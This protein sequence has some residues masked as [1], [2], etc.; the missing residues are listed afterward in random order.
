MNN[1]YLD[2]ENFSGG[3]SKEKRTLAN[4]IKAIL[5]DDCHDNMF[6]LLGSYQRTLADNALR[7]QWDEIHKKVHSLFSAGKAV[8]LDGPMIG[9]PVSIRDSDYFRETAKLF[10][11]ERSIAADIEWMATAWNSTFADTGLWMGKAF[12]PVSREV[13]A[14][15]TKDDEV[16]LAAYDPAITRIGRNYFRSPPDPNLLQGLSLPALT[17][18]WNLRKRPTLAAP[19]IFDTKLL[20]ENEKKEKNIPYTLTGGIFLADLGR[21][22]VP[23]MKGKAVYQLNY[24]W[25]RLNP[26]YP[27][28]R[29]V[30]EVVQIADGLYLGQLIYATQNYALHTIDADGAAH[31]LGIDYRP[32]QPKSF[33]DRLAFWRQ[34][35]EVVDYGYQNNGYFLMMDPDYAKQ[36]YADDAFPQL[37]PRAGE[38]GYQELGYDQSG[39]VPAIS[40]EPGAM[41]WV[42]GW[43]QDAKLA[44]KFTSFILEESPNP[45]DNNG[46]EAL[47]QEGESILQMLQRISNEISRQTAK[48]DQLRHFDTLSRL[49][50]CGVAPRV[51]EGVFQRYRDGAHNVLANGQ[52]QRDW[53][54]KPD[55]CT[56]F[57]Y[58]HGATLNLHCGFGENFES[59]AKVGEDNREMFPSILGE[60]LQLLLGTDPNI[61]NSTWQSI[62][63]YIFPWAGKSYEKVSG[64]K[65]SML[66]D[67]STDLTDR[68]PQRVAELKKY[69]ASAPHYLTL[70]KNQENFWGTAGH[71][72]PYL[73]NGSWDNGMSDEQKAFWEKESADHWVFGNN[74]QDARILPSDPLMN[75]IDMNYRVPDPTL[76]A[77]SE[78]GPS[79]FARQGY[80]FLGVSERDSILPMNNTEEKKKQVFQFQYRFP[81]IGGPAPIGYCLDEIVELADGLFLGQLIY[82]T[83]LDKTFHSGVDPSVYKYQLFGYFLLLDDDW[84]SHRK[85]IGLDVWDR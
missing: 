63:K 4:S 24:R 79:P 27:M 13:V 65:L 68:Y 32:H 50:R 28:T 66:L 57:D 78:T 29:L 51:K 81:M 76:Q 26:V 82:S 6:A 37:R 1:K 15:R 61:L 2:S 69:P 48:D 77:L 72:A 60:R 36:V 74:L 40:T 67:E 53:Y 75:I 52:Q 8:P 21:S 17:P 33:L 44:E 54:G 35:E 16:A 43:K 58:Y 42:E 62:G 85:A 84:Q 18:L 30:D 12:E 83:A 10:G 20:P 5:A 23:E 9:I 45:E 3:T 56:G 49:F 25:P 71:Y 19:E 55:P 11:R 34:K 80:V 38:S 70:L 47:K 22:V 64:R 31:Q 73:N 59:E 14:H 7:N 39:P 41:D 46:I